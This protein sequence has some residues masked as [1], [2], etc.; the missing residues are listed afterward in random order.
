MRIALGQIV[1]GKKFLAAF[2]PPSM[3]NMTRIQL[4]ADA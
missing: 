3:I 2:E 4:R 1:V